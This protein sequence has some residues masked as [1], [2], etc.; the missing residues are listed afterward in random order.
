MTSIAIRTAA[1]VLTLFVLFPAA[2]SAHG[3]KAVT[4][5]VNPRWS[6][7]SFQ[8][9]PSL[10]Q[11]AW[12]EF[13]KEAAMVAYFRPLTDASSFGK[14]NYEFSVV[15]WN[16]A[17]D[18]TKS[19]WN[20][21]FVHP[22]SVHWL[23]EGDRL[24]FPALTFRAGVT[25]RID[26]GLTWTKNPNANYG[27][28]GGQLQYALMND[29]ESEWSAAARLTASSLFGPDDLDFSVYGVDLLTSKRYE[30][31]K[32]WFSVT[33][34]A[35]ISLWHSRSH[36]TSAVVAL[37]DET[38]TG[39]QGTVGAVS[40]ISFARLGVEYNVAVVSTLSFKVGVNF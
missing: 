24:G 39:M 35:G 36:E 7:C 14:G 16:T 19:A 2:A 21:T 33:P 15:Q 34:Y 28:W 18:D 13:T 27:F 20:D 31:S 22:D 17:F 30:I 32:E 12:G 8:L 29:P 6:E 11:S 23:K 38:A 5:H 26:I 37:T 1:V 4:L 10:T 40:D 3:G 25:D 9:D